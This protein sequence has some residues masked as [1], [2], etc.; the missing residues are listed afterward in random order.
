MVQIRRQSLHRP[1]GRWFLIRRA[2]MRL[3][4]FLL[5]AGLMPLVFLIRYHYSSRRNK[6]PQQESHLRPPN[7]AQ[8]PDDIDIKPESGKSPS[9]HL[10]QHL[11]VEEQQQGPP[12]SP[13]VKNPQDIDYENKDD[14]IDTAQGLSEQSSS[15]ITRVLYDSQL[16]QSILSQS[17]MVELGHCDVSDFKTTGPSSQAFVTWATPLLHS[18]MEQ[19][20][21]EL[22]KQT[23]A[24]SIV[25]QSILES[26]QHEFVLELL[27]MYVTTIDTT[28]ERT[29]VAQAEEDNTPK[30][31][32][33]MTGSTR[34][35]CDFRRYRPTVPQTDSLRQAGETLLD[36]QANHLHGSSQQRRMGEEADPHEALVQGIS[37]EDDDENK[38]E[39]DPSLPRIAFI[40]I[41]HQDVPQLE[42]LIQAIHMP[43]HYIMIHLEE[44]G[45]EQED[46]S[47][48]N[49]QDVFDLADRYDNVVVVQFGTIVYR[50]DLV[51]HVHYRLLEWIHH[52]LKLQYD[53]H[54]CIGT[55]TYPLW[56]A[57]NLAQAIQS[58][59]R[60]VWLGELTHKGMRVTNPQDH[61]IQNKRLVYTTTPPKPAELESMQ[62]FEVLSQSAQKIHKRLPRS[63]FRDHPLP[64]TLSQS[65]KYKTNSGNQAVFSY[66]VVDELLASDV[67]GQLFALAKYGCCCCVEERT[68]I[69][70][71]DMVGYGASALQ[72][73][74]VFQVWGGTEVGTCGS[75]MG[76]AYL[77]QN[78][79]LCFRHEDATAM[80]DHITDNTENMYFWGRDMWRFLTDA[81]AR[82]F[83]FAR[84]FH[85]QHADSTGLLNEIQQKLWKED[86]E[87]LE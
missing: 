2:L 83:L 58:S 8:P 75:S 7:R 85:S 74:A 63:V 21:K 87:S 28:I 76:N 54:V 15:A 34:S 3:A 12:D 5:M 31:D 71:L 44:E 27:E 6:L 45:P 4:R 55:S 1:G 33:N 16:F 60:D 36:A 64:T 30:D 17:H 26:M 25:L 39:V 24:T 77:S 20:R 22:E 35:R 47:S 59:S 14:D 13:E 46:G 48:T 23:H 81:K 70:A 67:V 19:I 69:A 9:P 86:A 65:L 62:E 38:A 10:N 61:Y 79:S 37:P 29:D 68:W 73:A 56:D 82:G 41:F 32:D 40:V 43:Q 78:S 72:Q 52:D 66:A 49:Y 51:S 18:T 84:K 42:R 53:Y 57:E 50:T 80:E 11:P